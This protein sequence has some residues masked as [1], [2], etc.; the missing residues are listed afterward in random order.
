MQEEAR[1]KSI[2]FD[3]KLNTS[4]NPLLENVVSKDKFE[5]LIGDHLKD[6]IIAVESSK[7]SYKSILVT[8]GL[9]DG[10]YEFSVYDTGIEFEIDTLLKLGKEQVTTHKE[11]GGS[12]IGFI[13][14][15]ETLK[16]CKASLIIEEYNPEATNYTKSVNIRFDGKNQY[17]IY[18]YR[19]E[20][21]KKQ[22]P[23]SRIRIEKI[24]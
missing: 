8:F 17:K 3:L 2:N 18:S 19:A 15:F 6:A 14:T 24:K 1:K 20:E 11:E 4:I 21:I 22:K 10:M 7:A 5:T 23:E 16:E 13:T 9:I 12:G